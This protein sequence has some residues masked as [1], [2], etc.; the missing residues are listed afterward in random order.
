MATTLWPIMHRLS[1]LLS[2]K[3]ELEKAQQ[4][5]QVSKV[6]VLRTEFEATSQAIETALTQWKPCLLPNVAM[7]D[8]VLVLKD[9]EEDE[10]PEM[11]RLQSI[12]HNA[13]AY[14]HSAFV[15]LYR[16]IYGYSPKN[17][18]VQQHAHNA[19]HHC[20][21][22]T[23]ARGP[24]GALLWPLFAAA[25]EAISSEDRELAKK[26]FSEIEKRQGMTNIQEA[27]GII[28][29]VWKRI[30]ALDED[31]YTMNTEPDLWRKICAE[32]GVTIVF[33]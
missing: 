29:E 12:L 13:L 31:D 11:G 20:V 32:K 23:A 30:D 1:N 18:L 28:Q 10:M 6:A 4:M 2:T 26:A 19:L 7:C 33:G 5:K 24:M 25:C 17:A 8:G 14:R 22:T 16:T 21:E 3:K 27:W 9:V 15:Y